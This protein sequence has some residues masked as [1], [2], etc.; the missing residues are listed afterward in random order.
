MSLVKECWVI[1]R[2]LSFLSFCISPGPLE[3]HKVNIKMHRTRNWEFTEKWWEAAD[4]EE[5]LFTRDFISFLLD[6]KCR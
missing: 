3:L 6:H 2:L 5:S 1:M 4:K